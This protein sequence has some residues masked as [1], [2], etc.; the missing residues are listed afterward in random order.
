MDKE[1]FVQFWVD[2]L[3]E[4]KRGLLEKFFSEQNMKK[5]DELFAEIFKTESGE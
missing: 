1:D 3:G 5:A 4:E 2:E